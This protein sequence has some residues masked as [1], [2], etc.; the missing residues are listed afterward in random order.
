MLTGRH[1][2]EDYADPGYQD[3][4]L[5]R[6]PLTKAG[7]PNKDRVRDALARLHAHRDLYS[8][9]QFREIEERIHRA[10]RHFAEPIAW[11][12]PAPGHARDRRAATRRPRPGPALSVSRI[13]RVTEPSRTR[14]V[15]EVEIEDFSTDDI[16]RHRSRDDRRTGRR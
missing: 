13:H 15:R 11:A 7:H 1:G 8:A 12:T 6:Y 4:R 10:G 3:D 16:M 14:L 9:S 5:A 2:R